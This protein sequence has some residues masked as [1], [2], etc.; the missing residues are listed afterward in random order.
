MDSR[1][2]VIQFTEQFLLDFNYI[3]NYI[4]FELKNLYAAQN[5]YKKLIYI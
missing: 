2:F 5:I 3:F 1:K 4:C